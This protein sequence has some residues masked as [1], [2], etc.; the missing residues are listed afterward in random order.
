MKFFF[1]FENLEPVELPVRRP[2]TASPKGVIL[3][4]AWRKC[5]Q[6]KCCK[7]V[8]ASKSIHLNYNQNKN[9]FIILRFL[10]FLTKILN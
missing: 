8:I 9:C 5:T 4:L 1:F 3:I 10:A 2:P 6:S 7:N